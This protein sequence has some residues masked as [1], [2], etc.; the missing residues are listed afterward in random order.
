MSSRSGSSRGSRSGSS[1]SF[2]ETSMNEEIMKAADDIWA[3]EN[4]L[5]D[6]SN[7]TGEEYERVKRKVDIILNLSKEKRIAFKEAISR[8]MDMEIKIRE[9][10]TTKRNKLQELMAL[11][12][13][14]IKKMKDIYTKHKL[15]LKN[16]VPSV[17]ERIREEFILQFKESIEHNLSNM[18]KFISELLKSIQTSRT[19]PNAQNVQ[20]TQNTQSSGSHQS[21]VASNVADEG[22][23]QTTPLAEEVQKETRSR[24]VDIKRKELRRNLAKAEK[25][26]DFELSSQLEKTLRLSDYDLGQAYGF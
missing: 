10:S 13:E 12:R 3:S 19:L 14:N 1:S 8:F 18:Q 24:A 11:H 16:L 15:K 4:E 17:S 5:V 23:R 6:L 7:S 2:V 25:N 9:F 21:P 20:N 26:Q 22:R